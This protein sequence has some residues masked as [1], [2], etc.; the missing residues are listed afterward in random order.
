V[1]SVAKLSALVH[2]L[3]HR[4]VLMALG[5]FSLFA[6]LATA[7]LVPI[8]LARLPADYFLRAPSSKRRNPVILALKNLVGVLVVA[9][10]IALLFLPG[11]GLLTV[12]LGLGLLDF[13]GKRRVQLGVITRPTVLKTVNS[14]RQRAGRAPLQIPHRD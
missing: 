10:G 1:L 13:P 4:D 9:L 12:L 7:V 6:F 8:A 11:Q 14:L 2:A 5:A 3:V